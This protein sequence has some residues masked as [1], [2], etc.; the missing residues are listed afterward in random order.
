MSKYKIMQ[1]GTSELFRKSD[2]YIAY[3]LPRYLK[4]T[5]YNLY[6]YHLHPFEIVTHE[7]FLILSRIL[8]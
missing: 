7:N 8:K 5:F 1:R 3:I 2:I 6:K 4:W